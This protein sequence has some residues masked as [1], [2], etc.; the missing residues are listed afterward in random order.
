MD[1]EHAAR[2]AEATSRDVEDTMRLIFEWVRMRLLIGVVALLG[3]PLMAQGQAAS[4]AVAASANAATPAASAANSPNEPRKGQRRAAWWGSKVTPGWSM[5]TWSER[6]QHREK[7]WSFKTYDDCK[8]YLDQHHAA[9]Q[10]RAQE[11]GQAPLAQPPRDACA[12]LK[13]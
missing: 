10:A 13:P 6:N 2:V 4:P 1:W 3:T 11:K 8:A 9:M 5:M 7:M 12:R